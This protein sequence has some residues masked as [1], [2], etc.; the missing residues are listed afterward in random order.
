MKRSGATDPVRS[1]MRMWDT[2][3]SVVRFRK[4]ETDPVARRLRTALTVEDMRRIAKRRLPH[5]VF[6]YIDG[7]AEDER[8]LA[9]NSAA[10][11]LIEFCPNVLRDVSE[12]D[13]STT[14]LGKPV[15]MPLVLAPTGYTRL[16]H[17]QGELSVARAGERA[18]IPYS[19][20]TMS[21]RSI[22]EV[23]AVS[24]GAKWFQVYTWKDRGLVREMVERA[25]AAGYEAIILTVDTAVLGRRERDAR[26]GFSIP[27]RIGPGTIVDGIVHPAWTYDFMTHE[28][29]T[30]ANVAHLSQYGGDGDMG[31]GQYVMMNFDQKLAWSDVEWLQSVWSGPIVLKGIQT[32]DD[33]ERAVAAGVQAIALSNHGGRQLDD[34]PAPIALV[35][36]VA[37]AVQGQAEI[38]CDGGVR[39]GSD[40]VKAIAL[41]AAACSIG[42]PYLYAMGAAG[43]RGVDQLL[44]FFRDGIARTMAL[45]GRTTIAE[46]DR[47]LVRWR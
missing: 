35:E 43:E 2:F 6:D 16:T 19:L 10:F 47:G 39:R 32:V 29:M 30:F 40:I 20:S 28:P 45:S 9:N 1:A 7:G 22:E 21:T 3:R 15:S 33:A 42:R 11:G 8:A 36:P 25:A 37:Q 13:V 14:L 24:N 12:I 4:F 5:G 26:R 34:A 31:R 46:I 23:A 38:I 17:S 27:P 44:Q 18:G 41:G